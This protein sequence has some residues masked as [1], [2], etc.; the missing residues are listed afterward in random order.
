MKFY[1][2]FDSGME[3]AAQQE[4][5]KFTGSKVELSQGILTFDLDPKDLGKIIFHVQ[6]CVRILAA[7]DSFPSLDNLQF[8]FAW[9]NF[10]T[11]KTCKVE[12]ENVKGQ[13]NRIEIARKVIP[14]LLADMKKKSFNPAVDVKDPELVIVVYNSAEKYFFGVDLCGLLN[15]RAYR[16]FPHQASFKGDLGYF[17]ISELELKPGEKFVAGFCKDGVIPIEA[18]LSLNN[19]PLR[20]FRSIFPLLQD[21]QDSTPLTESQTVFA[22]DE[23]IQNVTAARKNAKLAKVP[24]DIQRY[25]LEDLD[26][27]YGENNFEKMILQI[28]RKDE[29]KINEIYYQISYILK[30]GGKLLLIGRETWELSISEK[31]KQVKQGQIQRGNSIHHYW[32]LE[33]I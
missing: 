4:I 22:F 32:L 3:N 10:D 23:S 18:S 11:A 20:K 24:C 1:A 21:L 30:Q 12:V 9:E 28:T 27:K 5:E 33:K 15:E 19:L 13:E 29:D 7:I 6:S 2:T 17:F 25:R 26:V 31:F 8:D 16:V 14:S